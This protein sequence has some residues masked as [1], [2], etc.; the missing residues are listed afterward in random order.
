MVIAAACD[1]EDAARGEVSYVVPR[2][3]DIDLK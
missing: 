1:L 3:E 2:S